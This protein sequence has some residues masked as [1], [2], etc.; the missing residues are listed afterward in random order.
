[1]IPVFLLIF[2]ILA[3]LSFKSTGEQQMRLWFTAKAF[4]VIP[5]IIWVSTFVFALTCWFVSI[6]FNFNAPDSKIMFPLAHP[7]EIAAG[8]EGN[9][10]CLS[11]LY[12]RLQIFDKNGR[13][14]RGWFVGLPAGAFRIFVNESDRI[15]VASENKRKIYYFDF[16]GNLLRISKIASDFNEKFGSKIRM[17]T[18]D[19]LGNRY[20]IE[21][22]FLFPKV[23][24][25]NTSGEKTALITQPFGH[26]LIT[27]PIPGFVFLMILVI[28]ESRLSRRLKTVRKY[29]QTKNAR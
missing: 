10:C 13:F 6:W 27:M 26:W 19:S 24:K 4:A 22:P 1:V 25:L 28:V 9:I 14:I 23:V 18:T 16:N 21:S 2:G 12:N 15:C 3:F 7:R 17:E 20:K 8:A 11:T 29:C 5:K